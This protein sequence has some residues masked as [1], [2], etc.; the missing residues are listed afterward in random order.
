MPN[1]VS[2][3]PDG[4]NLL[5]TNGSDGTI[6]IYTVD[7]NGALTLLATQTIS[8]API[9]T[10]SYAPTGNFIAV[11]DSTDDAISPLTYSATN[12]TSN[13]KCIK[14]TSWPRGHLTATASE[15]GDQYRVALSNPQFPACDIVSNAATLT[16]SGTITPAWPITLCY[17]GSVILTA[18]TSAVTPIYQWFTSA[19]NVTFNP[20]TGETLQTYETTTSAFYRVTI[21]GIPIPSVQLTVSLQVPATITPSGTV[22]INQGTSQLL[23]AT[24]GTG[25][26]YQWFKDDVFINNTQD[27]TI[28]DSGSYIVT[29]TDASSCSSTS[30]PT[31]IDVIPVGDI[32]V[33]ITPSIQEVELGGTAIFT[34]TVVI[35]T[36]TSLTW[37]GPNN[38]TATGNTITLTNVTRQ[39]LGQ[40]Y[41][42]AKNG[43]TT[44][45][46]SAS[47]GLKSSFNV[48]I[49][50]PSLMNILGSNVTLTAVISGNSGPFVYV[51]AGPNGFTFSSGKPT[52]TLEFFSRQDIGSYTVTVFDVNRNRDTAS[53][54]LAGVAVT[55]NSGSVTQDK[56]SNIITSSLNYEIEVIGGSIHGMAQMFSRKSLRQDKSAL[57]YL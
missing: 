47:L 9:G 11:P 15:T 18:Q 34:A 49:T 5:V 41:V 26:T 36:A 4:T 7:Q 3:S 30:V 46:F 17:G 29:V 16:I 2:F 53:I 19:D 8:S 54:D 45:T 10:A 38:F 56:N 23:S 6:S 21:N 14:N 42:T 32:S 39:M 27:I 22:Q 50:T 13:S 48:A 35:G 1:G 43:N 33:E 24:T 31:I 52:L 55:S 25:F 20:I 12:S 44:R 57:V 40:Y 51:W 37:T 28:T